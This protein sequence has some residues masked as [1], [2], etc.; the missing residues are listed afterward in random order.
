MRLQHCPLL[1]VKIVNRC[2]VTI[3]PRQPFIEWAKRQQPDLALPP[4]GFE[5]GLYL[6]PAPR[7][8]QQGGGHRAAGAGL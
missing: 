5:P 6:L 4:G 7:L 3:A 8:R 2:G 1:P